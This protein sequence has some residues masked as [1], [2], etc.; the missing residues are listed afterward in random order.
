MKREWV[1]ATMAVLG[2]MVLAYAAEPAE[3]QLPL[4]KRVAGDLVV[5]SVTLTPN[6]P[7]NGQVKV[8]I[9]LKN[10]GGNITKP[11]RTSLY[12]LYFAN[13]APTGATYTM[14]RPAEKRLDTVETASLAAG[15]ETSIESTFPAA[16]KCMLIVMADAPF[17]TVH[18]P[19]QSNAG[20]QQSLGTIAELSELNNAF[21]VPFDGTT[22]TQSYANPAVQ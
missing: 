18:D 19:L 8:T 12:M 6:V 2:L 17:D 10:A 16:G 11:F 3:R 20:T 21:A 15:A 22:Q 13:I 1:L 5:K 4:T 9:V 7:A 14:M